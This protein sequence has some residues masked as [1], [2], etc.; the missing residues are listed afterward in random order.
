MK[1]F[2]M[3][4]KIENRK[5]KSNNIKITYRILHLNIL[6]KELRHHVLL[7]C[8][9]VRGIADRIS[10]KIKKQKSLIYYILN[11]FHTLII[12]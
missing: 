5:F 12:K 10:C 9:E 6:S 7:F 2:K 4:D 1:Y 3:N 8:T 11:N